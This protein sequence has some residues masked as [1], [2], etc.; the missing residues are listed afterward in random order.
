MKKSLLFFT[1]IFLVTKCSS[2]T[3]LMMKHVNKN[4]MDVS[5]KIE[6]EHLLISVSAPSTGWVAVGFNTTDD[7][8]GTN[9]IMAAVAGSDVILSDRYILAPGKHSPVT[10][11]GGT[12]AAI[13]VSGNE[14]PVGTAITFRLPLLAQ[15]KFHFDLSPGRSFHLL[16][17]YSRED[18]FM[19]HSVMRTS[20]EIII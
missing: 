19:H 15:G 3:L 8:A 14:N 7:L 13:V 17:A 18:D 11:L 5:W 6:E 1:L 16:M 10:E 4:G 20:V 12:E 9:L 2:Q